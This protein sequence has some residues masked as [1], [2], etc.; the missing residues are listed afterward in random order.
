MSLIEVTKYFDQIEKHIND[1]KT[2]IEGAKKELS[3][4]K[5][6]ELKKF[7][8]ALKINAEEM[9]KKSDLIDAIIKTYTTTSEGESEDMEQM[10]LGDMGKKGIEQVD[11]KR[12]KADDEQPKPTPRSFGVETVQLLLDKLDESPLNFFHP[13]KEAKYKEV[14]DSIEALGLLTPLI[15]RPKDDG[16]YEILA[17][18]NRAKICKELG[19]ADV[20]A[21]IKNVDDLEAEEI[22]ADTNVAQRDEKTPLEIAKAYEIKARAIGK[23]QGRRS[24][25]E[26]GTDKGSWRDKVGKEFEVSGMT[27]ERY[28]RLNNLLPEF[29]Q[30]L[31]E[32]KINVKTCFELGLLDK[33]TQKS[34]LGSIN[35][36]KEEEVAMINP[37]T[38][39]KIKKKLSEKNSLSKDEKKALKKDGKEPQNKPLTSR[40]VEDLLKAVVAENSGEGPGS[41]DTT[42]KFVIPESYKEITEYFT[43]DP[44]LILDL[45]KGYYEGTVQFIKNDE[46]NG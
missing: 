9:N 43:S 20:P 37:K 21:I 39:T 35:T 46:I 11:D 28:M 40:E 16:R 38:V 29:Q 31:D 36:K 32:N 42:I 5:T 26:D 19:W 24:D 41:A 34:L 12:D 30:L 23:R 15:V 1:E 8:I 10:K 45:V 44:K 7:A 25:L 2:D 6:A 14:K 17:G 27:V 18:H 22:I 3:A 13:L 4:I 33:T